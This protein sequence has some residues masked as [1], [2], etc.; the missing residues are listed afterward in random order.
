MT[1]TNHH[2]LTGK[3]DITSNLLVG[4]SHLFVDTN[5]NRVGLVT[6]NPDAGLHVNSNAYVNTDLRVGSQIEINAT[7]GHIKAGSFEGDGSLLENTPPGPA[8]TIDGVSAT[9]GPEGTNA[10]ATNSGTSSAAV[11]DFVIPRGD[12]GPTGPTGL[13]GS[14]GPTGPTGPTGGTG[15]TGVQGPT[16][17]TGLTGDTGPT[18]PPGPTGLTGVQGP[19]GNT[20]IDG[21]TGPNGPPGLTGVTGSPGPSGPPGP[22]GPASTV[23]GP[24]GAA[25]TVAGPP[26]TNYFTLSG[27]NIYRSTGNVGIGTTSPGA[28]L[29]VAAQHGSISL[30]MVHFRANRDSASNGD[31]N[32]LKLEN[33]GN[34]SDVELLECVSSGNTR[35]VVKA[36]GKVGVGTVSPNN[37]LDVQFTGDSGIR[38]KNTGTST[39]DHAS[40]YIDAGSGYGYLRF[41]H[42][43]TDKFWIQSTPTGDLAFRPNGTSHVFDINNSGYTRVSAGDSA[44]YVQTDHG[45]SI[46]RNYGTTLGAG[47]HFTD[48]AIIPADH[49]GTNHH[50]NAVD[51]GATSYKW[52]NLYVHNY[53]HVGSQI[54]TYELDL[55]RQR[56]VSSYGTYL[57]WP[58][59]GHHID[60]YRSGASHVFHINHYAQ[61]TVYLNRSGYSDRRI[62]EDIKDIDDVS[63]LNILRKIKPKT[64]KYKLQPN[65]GTVYGFIAQDVREVLPYATNLTKLSAP[66][67]RE[68]FVDAN[69]LEDGTVELV[70]PCEQI[71]VG[72]NAHFYYETSIST[73]DFT[74]LEILSPTRFKVE[75]DSIDKEWTGQTKLVGKEVDDFH[76]IDKDAIFTVATAALQEVDRQLQSE[77]NKV[78]TMELLVA[79]LVKRVGDLENN[80]E[81]LGKL[82]EEERNKFQVYV[83]QYS[84]KMMQTFKHEMEEHITRACVRI[85]NMITPKYDE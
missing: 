81:T 6:T 53:A 70:S 49:N 12:T 43:G 30:P 16:G 83:I 54:Y 68:D 63:A 85:S 26:G 17:P 39:G 44:S 52:R 51:L 36:N 80:V 14:T 59:N 74:V 45:G 42:S 8:A 3:V 58:N 38:A 19:I 28:T 29:D 62:K 75:V 48:N 60:C 61:Q 56:R 47:I 5:N 40:V 31:G 27:S 2:V 64:Y 11:F 24:P 79:S 22:P 34:R 18:G 76:G 82:L 78:A 15:L 41:Q 4:S 23:P 9:T 13:T 84:Y 69:I 67:D 73:R 55:R 46:W 35:F 66:F 65:K 37:P 1:D 7:A 25:S 33:S 77:K 50:T 71:E 72:K 21:P 10:S 57:E 20:G 32:V